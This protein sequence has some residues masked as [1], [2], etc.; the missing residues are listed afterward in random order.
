MT[1]KDIAAKCGVS[2]STV[3]RV[4]NNYP[5]VKEDIR[6]QVLRVIEEEHFV[7]HNGAVSL[8]KPPAD[9][10]GV[11]IRGTGNHFFQEI[12]HVI[13]TA[14]EEAGYKFLMRQITMEADE[15]RA[16]AAFAKEKGLKGLVL[17][18]GRF[19]WTEEEAAILTTPFVCCTFTNKFGELSS[20]RY[21]S[22]AIDD[23]EEA[24]RATKFLIDHGHKDIAIVVASKKD[25]SVSQ[26][27]YEG[28]R[29][30]L[31]DAGLE[32]DD[33]LVI[34]TGSFHMD[35]AY[36]AVSKAIKKGLAFT[37]LFVISDFM[38]MAAIKAL[39]EDGRQVPKDCSVIAIDGV[40]MSKY[41][42]PTLTTLVQPR[43]EIA[44]NA[45]EILIRMIEGTSKSAQFLLNADL[46]EGGSV[47]Q[48]S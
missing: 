16:A 45:I 23:K 1:I 2:V 36:E 5:Y 34:E 39:A 12:I 14:I 9:S 24:Y 41:I 26:L 13:Q 10:I 6:E 48:L 47:R 25:H 35:D 3:S 37:G 20:S 43:K 40:E 15:L 38:A 33:R 11:L 21:S 8:V 44:Q 19:D 27:R 28:Y 46:R 30:A 22:V 31:M 32:P 7:P 17:L 42:I 4:L 18:G 29:K